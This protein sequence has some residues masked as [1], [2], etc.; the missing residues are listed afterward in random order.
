MHVQISIIIYLVL[1]VY[2]FHHYG[3][4][5]SDSREASVHGFPHSGSSHRS[6]ASTQDRETLFSDTI[7]C[8]QSA[9]DTIDQS[10]QASPTLQHRDKVTVIRDKLISMMHIVKVFNPYDSVSLDTFYSAL[11]CTI[12]GSF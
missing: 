7:Q 2:I 8:L 4:R 11:S 3:I 10:L 12:S 5:G 9:L 1:F 6:T